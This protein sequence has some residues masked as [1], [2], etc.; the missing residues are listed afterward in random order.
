MVSA[1]PRVALLLGLVPCCLALAGGHPIRR[2]AEVDVS[3]LPFAQDEPSI[4]ADPRNPRVLLA[5]SN[6]LQEGVVR[7]YTSRD[8]G[9]SWQ[10]GSAPRPV[11]ATDRAVD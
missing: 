5:A 6:S 10:K 9:V 3:A 2:G 11:P 7:V 1:L 4:A 8:G